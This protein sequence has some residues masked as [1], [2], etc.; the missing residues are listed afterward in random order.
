MEVLNVEMDP[1][2]PIQLQRR[3]L[4]WQSTLKECCHHSAT[5]ELARCGDIV[6]NS[7]K[8]QGGTI[9]EPKWHQSDK[10]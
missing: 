7:I 10:G 6:Q 4:Q 3:I 9:E 1:I 8:K 5:L 2:N